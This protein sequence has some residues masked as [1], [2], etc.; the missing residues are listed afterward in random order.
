MSALH[1]ILVLLVAYVAV[2]C[3]CRIGFVRQWTLAQIDV[4]P[5][6]MVY[7]GLR[8]GMVTLTLLAVA[9]GLWFDSLSAN[10]PGV[11]IVPLLAVGLLIHRQRTLILR[12]LP[13]AQFI[14]GVLAG[15]LAPLLTMILLLSLGQEPLLGWGTLWQ[16][17]VLALGAGVL[18]PGV[19]WLLDRLE[20][21]FAYRPEA[22]TS[23][24]L[25][26]EIKR[27]RQ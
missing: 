27:G 15:A 3:E 26:R 6:L 11:S 18:T 12:D 8:S 5:A 20:G 2:F 16:W 13:Y 25:D 4:L 24:R 21:W 22:A 1:G 9:G 10:P 7:A 14:L 23:F 19:F 17:T